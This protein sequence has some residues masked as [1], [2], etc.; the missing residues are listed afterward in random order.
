MLFM[1]CL[2]RLAWGRSERTMILFFMPLNS[3]VR[4][5]HIAGSWS[6]TARP[7]RHHPCDGL[8]RPLPGAGLIGRKY[9]PQ[10]IAG[11]MAGTTLIRRTSTRSAH[12][13]PKYIRAKAG[14][15]ARHRHGL[16]RLRPWRD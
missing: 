12:G 11:I 6:A 10:V 9:L 16:R 15:R 5:W 1:V 8:E 2:R 7:R 14:A 4:C 13:F 3:D